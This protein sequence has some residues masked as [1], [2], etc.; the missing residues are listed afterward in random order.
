MEAS[1]NNILVRVRANDKESG[2]KSI[3]Y[4]INDKSKEIEDKK[5]IE[6][7]DKIYL[8]DNL[9]KNTEY[10]IKVKVT[11]GNDKVSEQTINIKTEQIEN[12]NITYTNTPTTPI[13]E[14]LEKQV[15]N[16]TFNNSNITTPSYYIKTTRK[17][18]SNLNVNSSCGTGL[19]PETCSNITSTNILDV[20]T[21]YKVTGNVNVTYSNP[22]DITD[23]LYAIAY[24]G[25]NYSGAST[26]AISKIIQPVTEISLNRT[27][28][29]L[30]NDS[31]LQLIATVIPN[32]ATN[33]M[34]TWTSSNI[35]I[36]TVDSNG[37]V[38][39]KGKL[40]TT[41]IT[42]ASNSGKM[43]S[44][45]ITVNKT[46]LANIVNVGDYV[47]YDAGT[48]T[49]SASTPTIH[50]EFGGYTAGDN[51]ANSTSACWPFYTPNLNG[52]RVLKI[53]NKQVYLV[54]AGQPE[55]YYHKVGGNATV[56]IANLNNRATSQYLNADYASSAHNINK[57][58]LE[59]IAQSN[60]LRMTGLWYWSASHCSDNFMCNI[61]SDGNIYY[62]NDEFDDAF[63]IRPVIV[64]K[65]GIK[66]TGKTTDVVGQVAWSLVAP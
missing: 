45:T 24:D 62:Y 48:W 41:T 58:E 53:E 19:E 3:E 59:S 44:A 52:W 57:D 28:V 40:G 4:I 16:V 50:G 66:T 1:S 30:E 12:P 26:G 61:A 39:A 29:T 56:S 55:C 60:N 21:W 17:G 6:M 22:S 10:Q 64:L 32:N 42:A 25:R 20:N 14:Y 5:L 35:D 51:K 38:T 49:S 23:T 34:I 15:I 54:H 63:G 7:V 33:K 47:A 13:D 31:T 65:E 43:V 37:L 46:Y 9:D 27:S 18:T 11:N 36:A 2:I 8:F